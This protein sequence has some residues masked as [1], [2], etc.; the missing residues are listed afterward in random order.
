MQPAGRL[1]GVDDRERAHRGRRLDDR[2]VVGEPAIRRLHRAPRHGRGPW[3]D[4][5]CERLQRHFANGDAASLLHE[6][7]EQQ[8]RELAA[9]SQHLG[10]RW[11]AG[12]EHPD[13]V[14]GRRTKRNRLGRCADERCEDT[15][16]W[17]AASF[18]VRQS[19]APSAQSS[20]TCLVRSTVC[21]VEPYVAVSR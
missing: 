13:Q 9:G 16:A 1:R 4:R 11:K 17:S 19:T 6:E 20:S 8:R 12:G 10:A 21:G 14:G 3:T 18:H 7:R 15:A 2:A 5:V